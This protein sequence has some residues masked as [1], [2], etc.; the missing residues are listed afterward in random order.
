M[1]CY[2]CQEELIR[3]ELHYKYECIKCPLEVNH[4]YSI[5]YFSDVNQL[6]STKI[7]MGK[8]DIYYYLISSVYNHNLKCKILN[9]ETNNIL[10]SL[11]YDPNITPSNAQE[12]IKLLLTFQ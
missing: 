8:Y 1:N 10:I 9:T 11:P 4:F 2:F 5:N 12:K 7:I 3:A 6:Y